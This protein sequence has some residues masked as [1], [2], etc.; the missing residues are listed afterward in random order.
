MFNTGENVKYDVL[1]YFSE[2]SGHEGNPMLS[3]S[4]GIYVSSR[5]SCFRIALWTQMAST[6]EKQFKY[7][8]HRRKLHTAQN[9]NEYLTLN[10]VQE[11]MTSY[12]PATLSLFYSADIC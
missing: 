6:N 1:T 8:V 7:Q 10:S 2:G 11:L 12:F 4:S 3:G 9:V 5:T